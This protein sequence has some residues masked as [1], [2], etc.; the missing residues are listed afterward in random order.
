M[1]NVAIIGCGNISPAHIK[2][3]LTFPERCKIVAFVD[4]YPEKAEKRAK[5]YAP[6]A[7]VLDSHKKLLARDDIDLISVCTPPYTHADIACDFLLDGKNVIVEKPMASSLAECD[8]IIEAQRIGGGTLSVIAQNRFR[9]PIMHLKQT[10]DAGLIGEVLHF[11]V[12]SH[13]WRGHCY[14]DLWWRG[15]WEKEGGGCTLNHAVHHIDMLN[16]M[17]GLP[18]KV[19]AVMSN[20]AHDNAEVEDLSIAILEYP[21]GTLAQV[22]SSVVHHGE[23]QNIIIQGEKAKIMAPWEVFAS[24]SMEN[25]FPKRNVELENE[26]KDYYDSLPELTYEGHV[27]QIDD[28]LT[29]IETR[30]EVLIKGNDGRKTVELITAIYKAGCTR[31]TVTLPLVA[32]DDFYTVEGIR[33]NAIYFYQK[34]T[35]IENFD[36]ISITTG[37]NYK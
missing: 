20:T 19:T 17:M 22:T 1:L 37:S 7:E 18:E 14:Y 36:D 26:I 9:N 21:K 33:K 25:G 8:R 29:A 30:V 5:E 15:S 13:W 27:G 24:T 6:D 12:D 11:Q 32:E 35:S 16:W 34:G 2:A 23:D 28:V 31:S 4:I 3:Y 10:M